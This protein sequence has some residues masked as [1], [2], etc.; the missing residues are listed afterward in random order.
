[1]RALSVKD[2]GTID[3][4]SGSM[5]DKM[6]LYTLPIIFSNFMQL[7]YNAVDIAVVGQFTGEDAVASVGATSPIIHVIVNVFIGISVGSAIR[8]SYYIG[9]K[10]EE[11]VRKTTHTSMAAGILFGLVG[12][13]VGM[14]L[15]RPGLIAMKTHPSLIPDALTYMY[16]Y[17][18]GMIFSSVYNFGAVILRAGGETRK[19]MIYLLVSG[20]A[21]VALNF[22]LTGLMGLGVIGVA[23]GT[24]VSQ[25]ISAILVTVELVRTKEVYRIELKQIRIWWGKFGEIIKAGLPAGVQT[26]MFSFANLF[27]QSSINACDVAVGANNMLIAG[28]TASGT[29]EGMLTTCIGSFGTTVTT[30][31]GQNYGAGKMDRVD[32]VPKL[33]GLTCLCIWVVIATL[34]LVGAPFFLSL[35]VDNPLALYYGAIKMKVVVCGCIFNMVAD[36]F[37]AQSRALGNS[38]TPMIV[39]VMTICV[40]RV[41]YL[42]TIQPMIGSYLSIILVFPISYAINTVFQAIL[43]RRTRRHVGIV[44]AARQGLR[45]NGEE[46]IA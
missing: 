39:S 5:W 14:V 26:A 8:V 44:M 29:I 18:S 17:L 43:Y 20:L 37:I 16:L 34:A 46:K 30:F 13:V 35:S 15:A 42:H 28:Y 21:N 22:L 9:A 33:V 19:P 38:F 12:M 41:I 32:R 27:V 1:V 6:I 3:P 7:L 36:L 40:F 10:S 11:D 31:A 25:L 4:C 45:P 24:V 23:A 2:R